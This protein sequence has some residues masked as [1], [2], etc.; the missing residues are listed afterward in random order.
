VA[1]EIV[2]EFSEALRKFFNGFWRKL[3]LCRKFYREKNLTGWMKWA[4]ERAKTGC[5]KSWRRVRD[6]NPQALWAAVFKT[7]D[8]PISLTL[9][10]G[11]EQK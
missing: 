2:N 1:G 9:R 7:A 10:E 6:S 3:K 8:L 4:R 11:R 5:E